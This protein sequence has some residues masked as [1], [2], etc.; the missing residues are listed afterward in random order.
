MR[1][2]FWLKSLKET[3]HSE[4]LD[5]DGMIILF[6]GHRVGRFGLDSSG[7]GE[8]LMAGFCEHGSEPLDS[9]KRWGIS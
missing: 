2:K 1:T 9:I 6:Y 8:G 5:I 3:D 4:V 7:S